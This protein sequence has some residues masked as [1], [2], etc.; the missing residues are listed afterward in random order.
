MNRPVRLIFVAAIVL[1]TATPALAGAPQG[2][3]DFAPPAFV[4]LLAMSCGCAVVCVLAFITVLV[5]AYR[6]D[7]KR[8]DWP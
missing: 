6:A 7:R 8:N 5:F 2:D 1:L 3:G 4:G